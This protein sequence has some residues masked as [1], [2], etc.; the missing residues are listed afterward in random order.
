MV[1]DISKL[2]PFTGYY[3]MSVGAGAFLSIDTVEKRF[4]PPGHA[5][6]PLHEI[7]EI[8]INVS[9]DGR[10]SATYSF[11][12]EGTFNGSRLNIPGRLT[13]DFRRE[14]QKGRLAS[15][16][17]TI[18]GVNVS[19]E[20]Y[21][22]QVPLSA[23]VGNYYDVQTSRSALSV[24]DSLAVLFDF[25]I[26][27]NGPARELRRV[28]S[29]NY[30]PAMFVLTFSDKSSA[31]PSKFTLMLGTAGKNGLACSI[32]GGGAPRLAVSI[33]PFTPKG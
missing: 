28:Q 21:F 33:L 16:A 10:S 20:T 4:M 26:F 29:Y 19:G 11:N 3:S 13:L 18:E 6:S 25:D 24:T 22:N 1:T 30:A 7:I 27:L 14:Y 15:F 17:G 31:Q 12:Q 32:Q 8:S 5:T 23:F 2:V 9:M